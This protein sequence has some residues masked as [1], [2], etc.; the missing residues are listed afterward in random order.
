MSDLLAIQ[1]DIAMSITQKLRLRL[2]GSESASVSKKYTD[3]NEAYQL[4]LRGR[5]HW[6]KRSKAD[7]EQGIVFFRQ[8]IDRDPNFA[9][10]TSESLTLTP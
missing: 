10:H 8:A 1:R 6:N 5:H 7:V 2:S 4:Y 9:L 3:N